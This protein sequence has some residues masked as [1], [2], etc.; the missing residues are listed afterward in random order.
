MYFPNSENKGA[1]QLQGYRKADLRLCFRICKNPVFSRGGISFPTKKIIKVNSEYKLILQKDKSNRIVTY[2]D[3]REQQL[4]IDTVATSISKEKYAINIR[5]D[6]IVV[7]A[8]N[9]CCLISL[10]TIIIWETKW[11]LFSLA[12]IISP[13]YACVKVLTV[14]VAYH[15]IEL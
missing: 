5:Q 9:F 1:D 14:P 4:P 15:T 10:A 6:V 8:Y 7:A 3:S 12:N 11:H 13:M 2:A